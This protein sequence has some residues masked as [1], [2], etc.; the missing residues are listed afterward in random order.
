MTHN[1]V[2][3]VAAIAIALCSAAAYSTPLPVDATTINVDTIAALSGATLV[4]S[5]SSNINN[6]SYNGIARAAVYST[7]TGLDFLYQFT[8]NASAV[9][10]LERLTA[11]D[12]SPV[13]ATTVLNVF[14][15]AAAFGIF[16]AGADAA[17][18]A[19]RTSL[20]VI[21]FNFSPGGNA[22]INPG[23]T[24]FTEIIATNATTYVAGNFG[25]LDGIGDNAQAY[26][27]AASVPEPGTYLLML[28]GVGALLWARRQ[29]D[30]AI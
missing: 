25:L 29:P 14:Q 20:G 13:G 12:F 6:L 17:N 2:R 1:S 30:A 24:S 23:T 26:A 16:T 19:D 9:N 15:T 18:T 21:G 5:E 3:L 7:S 27:P 4:A 11:Y 28:L 8:N 10:G 22:K